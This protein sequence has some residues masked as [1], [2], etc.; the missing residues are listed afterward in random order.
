MTT[1]SRLITEHEATALRDCARASMSGSLEIFLP[2]QDRIALGFTDGT[3]FRLV[4]KVG[5]RPVYNEADIKREKLG[6]W[7]RHWFKFG[8]RCRLCKVR[9]GD[10]E[11]AIAFALNPDNSPRDR[12][13]WRKA[14]IHAEGCPNVH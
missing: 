14:F 5:T 11:K 2:G 8:P 7:P 10:G 12:A 1:M 6:L 3:P 4:V 9:I 13:Q